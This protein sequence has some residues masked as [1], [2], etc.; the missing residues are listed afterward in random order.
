[1]HEKRFFCTQSLNKVKIETRV[2]KE[3][4]THIYIWNTMCLDYIFE[5]HFIS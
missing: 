3:R 5:F 2:A 4:N 1:M